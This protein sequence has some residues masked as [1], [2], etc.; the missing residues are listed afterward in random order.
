M[1]GPPYAMPVPVLPSQRP[2][3]WLSWGT[4]ATLFDVDSSGLPSVTPANALLEIM[5]VNL[6]LGLLSVGLCLSMGQHYRRSMWVSR[7]CLG[8]S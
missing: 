7:G 8:V 4:A 2:W 5:G 3:N 6:E 1:S